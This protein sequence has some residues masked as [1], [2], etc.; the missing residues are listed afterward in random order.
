MT[1][2]VD[3]VPMDSK[4]GYGIVNQG[5]EGSTRTLVL[6]DIQISTH[7]YPVED[8]TMPTDLP[9]NGSAIEQYGGDKIIMAFATLKSSNTLR[10]YYVNDRKVPVYAFGKTLT[11]GSYINDIRVVGS[12]LYVVCE[13]PNGSHMYCYDITNFE[14]WVEL[15][16][17]HLDTANGEPRDLAIKDNYMATVSWF[18]DTAGLCIYNLSSGAPVFIS[19]TPIPSAGRAVKWIGD[20]IVV[21]MHSDSG[22]ANDQLRFYDASNLSPRVPLPVISSALGVTTG[23]I[24]GLEGYGEYVYAS[25]YQYNPEIYVFKLPSV[26]YP[27]ADIGQIRTDWLDVTQ[28]ARISGKL[29]CAGMMNVNGINSGESISTQ[30]DLSSF[31]S[32]SIGW[33]TEAELK[34]I[35]PKLKGLIYYDSTNDEF[36]RSTGTV[37]SLDWAKIDDKTAVPTGW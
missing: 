18:Y 11:L 1:P 30:K 14:N 26:H 10:G 4:Y 6:V 8:C 15:W 37:T 16:N 13:S 9:A 20:V 19:S 34:A 7:V 2:M 12:R 17:T 35:T 32:L 33:K 28:G 27:T 31:G 25:C 5:A 21:G 36:V 29:D 3:F 23:N 24:D 22:A